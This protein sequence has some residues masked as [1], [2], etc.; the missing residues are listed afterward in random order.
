[1][2]R[3][4]K[5]VCS[6]F[7]KKNTKKNKA[8]AGRAGIIDVDIYEDYFFA[9]ILITFRFL[10]IVLVFFGPILRLSSSSWILLWAGME[11]SLIGLL[12][13][14][15]ITKTSLSIERS[16][17]YFLVQACA[18]VIIL[19]TGIHLFLIKDFNFYFISGF[20]LGLILKLGLFPLHFWVVPILKGLN[21][22]L[23]YLI[24]GPLKVVPLILLLVEI[25][26]RKEIFIFL[27]F[28]SI[29]S[30][31][32]GSLLGNNLTEVRGVLGA[33]SIS[34]TG[35]VVLASVV[36]GIWIYFLFYLRRLY[37]LLLSLSVKNNI[38]TSVAILRLRGLPPFILFPAKTFVLFNFLNIYN[39]YIVLIVVIIR[40]VISLN[41]YLK[42]SY[43]FY[44]RRRL[45]KKN[46]LIL[47]LLI[48]NIL[49]GILIFL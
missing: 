12:P 7:I 11:L 43:S 19:V 36:G 41:F 35:W 33:S 31:I 16:L 48:L 44:L 28:T 46:Y 34:H 40:A 20:S 38:L 5:H 47:R 37:I 1:M 26:I 45:N 32:I 24:L 29:I 25:N 9:A 18:R 23:I 10:F 6:V 39:S 4:F 2:K 3:C 8:A 14:I 17:K 22:N 30:I 13:L 27:L 15:N 21:L 49:G 42:F